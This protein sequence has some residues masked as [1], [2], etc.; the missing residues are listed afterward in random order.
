[1]AKYYVALTLSKE[2][3]ADNEDVINEKI[4]N[5]IQK[6]ED[7]NWEVSLEACETDDDITDDD[8]IEE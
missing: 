5:L 2:I 8:C 1:M 3:V 4:E 6:F 7:K